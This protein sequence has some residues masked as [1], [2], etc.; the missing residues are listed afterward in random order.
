ML[1]KLLDVGCHLCINRLQCRHCLKMDE[2]DA[3]GSK[4]GNQSDPVFSGWASDVLLAGGVN[5]EWRLAA[6]WMLVKTGMKSY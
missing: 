1:L 2:V 5:M 3:G 6:V 4:P